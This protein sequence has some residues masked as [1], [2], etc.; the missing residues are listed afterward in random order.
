MIVVAYCV[1]KLCCMG[2]ILMAEGILDKL[3]ELP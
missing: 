3:A 1:E 2:D